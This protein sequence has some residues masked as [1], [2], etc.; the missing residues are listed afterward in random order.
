M[1]S[2]R[3]L[4]KSDGMTSSQATYARDNY[5]LYRL[6]ARLPN[7]YVGRPTK[8]QIILDAADHIE[9]QQ[10]QI[11]S[12]NR[13]LAA[14]EDQ[15]KKMV[16]KVVSHGEEKA[17]LAADLK[18]CYTKLDGIKDA[19]IKHHHDKNFEKFYESIESIM[20]CGKDVIKDDKKEDTQDKDKNNEEEQMYTLHCN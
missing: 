18:K 9:S 16:Q 3:D 4:P 5:A 7:E 10:E 15:L 13:K 1:I 19:L 6:E 14:R 20:V 12:L 8:R 11:S 2:P 17:A